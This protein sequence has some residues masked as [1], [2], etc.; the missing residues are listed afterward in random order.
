[1][2]PLNLSNIFSREKLILFLLSI[3]FFT[4]YSLPAIAQHH[5]G[6]DDN[7]HEEGT[8]MHG[9]HNALFDM[10]PHADATHIAHQNGLWSYPNTWMAGVVPGNNAR[11]L[12]AENVT[13]TYSGLSDIR[14]QWIRIDG[15]LNF[16]Q[17]VNSRLVVDTLIVDADGRWEIGTQENPITGSV[18]IIIANNGDIDTTWDAS[19]LSRG[20]ISHGAIEIYGQKK[21]VHGKVDVNINAGDTTLQMAES[22]DGWQVGDTLVIAGTSFGGYDWDND[23]ACVRWWETED[24]VRTITSI[25]DRTI[26]LNTALEF[27][28]NTSRNDL[29]LSVANYTRSVTVSSE[30]GATTPVHQRGHVMFMHSDNVDVRHAAFWHLGRTDKSFLSM[31]APDFGELITPISNVRGRYSLHIHRTGYNDVE[32][33]VLLIGNAVFGSPGWGYVH[34]DANAVLHNSASFDSFG[35]G[36]VAETGNEIGTWTNNIAIKAQGRNLANKN[37]ESIPLFDNGNTGVGCFFQGRNVKS[38]N[39]VAASIRTGYLFMHWPAAP[40]SS[41]NNLLTPPDLFDHPEAIYHGL[42]DVTNPDSADTMIRVQAIPITQFSDNESFAAEMGLHFLKNGP[43]QGHDVHSH[44][45]GFTAWQVRTGA[46]FEYTG[47]YII[48]DFDLL[49]AGPHGY[50]HEAMVLHTFTHDMTV[51][52][53]RIENYNHGIVFEREWHGH[54]PDDRI[55]YTLISP[56]FENVDQ[57]YVNMD[58]TVDA[59]ISESDL[60]P[61]RF[62]LVG[63]LS[64]QEQEFGNYWLVPGSNDY[65]M[66]SIG[67][68]YFEHGLEGY[69]YGHERT[70]VPQSIAA[71]TGYRRAADGT[72]YIIVEEY[73]TDRATN[74]K[75]KLGRV[76]SLALFNDQLGIGDWSAAFEAGAINLASQPPQAVDDTANTPLEPKL[77]ITDLLHND[78]DPEADILRVDGFTQ[79][80][81]G[82]AYALGNDILY[83]PDFDFVGQDEITYWATDDQGNFSPA[84]ITITVS[85]ESPLDS[86][87]DGVPDN[88]DAFPNDPTETTDSDGEGVGDNADAYP[89]DPTRSSD[90]VACAYEGQ[91]CEVPG[92]A[93]V[94]YGANGTYSSMHNVSGSIACTN[95]IFGDPIFGVYKH[96]DYRLGDT[97]V[98]TDGDGV[99]DNED[100][101][102]NDPTETT[103]SDGVGDNSDLYPNDTTRS[104][105]WVACANEGQTCEVPNTTTVRYGASGSYVEIDNVSGSILCTNS[106]FGD[107]IF[108]VYKH[109]DYRLDNNDAAPGNDRVPS[110]MSVRQI[111]SGHRLT[112]AGMFAQPWPGHSILMWEEVDPSHNYYEILGS[113][114]IPGS[115]MHWRW[116]NNVGHGAPEAL[117]DIAD[118]ELLVITE[119]V[120]FILG[121]GTAP[122]SAWENDHLAWM[123]TWVEHAW[124]NGDNGN[125]INTLLYS[126][127]TGLEQ[128]E[129]A[130]RAEL[131]TY[132]PLWEQMA[133]YGASNLPEA[134][135]VYIIPGN[136]LIMRLYDD[137]QAG[138][139]PDVTNIRDF[140]ADDIHPNGLGSYALG[141]LH[142]AV[143]HHVDPDVMSHTGHQLS[144]EPTPA[145]AEYLQRIV[146]E[147][148]RNYDR[149]GFPDLADP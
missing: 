103:D 107:P 105:D 138:Q 69:G 60:V 93:T 50:S 139:V 47:H 106:V 14:I 85:A 143:I 136:L 48:E 15:E 117:H 23:C 53:P 25:N 54:I 44:M 74:Q 144:P 6:D 3:L 101:F 140:F 43:Q 27:D 37:S 97:V 130:W 56:Q 19:L 73:Y 35:A 123:R 49:G 134:A 128:G 115:P 38:R 75:H 78:S 29:Q 72:S 119:G 109:C 113:S 64:W 147:I 42:E 121:E 24:E 127:W 94:R 131:D 82:I 104:A 91:T 10:V 87:G 146:W 4:A 76:V 51:I 102:P 61:N 63:N 77:S 66:Y 67:Q 28:H 95:A 112:D 26:T 111:H 16:A 116:N 135:R 98:D 90:W 141:L 36:F 108:G 99:P 41:T 55:N 5:H 33:P 31:E 18:D 39:N 133:D 132:Q 68:Q 129:A 148:A 149:A 84:T 7:M 11:V 57:P 100:A 124:N 17:Q 81:H 46:F 79:P 89:N 125:G 12:I 21:R 1:M 20:I 86:D 22:P 40:E 142:L 13:V 92:T 65:K 88:Q 83:Y 58:L 96:C 8:T 80:K 30:S 2:C 9:E 126:T 59:L 71:T 145:L 120:P 62:D 118:W 70:R 52:R 122:G 137:I 45:K 34:H 114:T 32:N 110:P